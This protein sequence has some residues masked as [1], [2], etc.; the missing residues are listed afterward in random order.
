MKKKPATQPRGFRTLTPSLAVSDVRQAI[1]FYTHAFGAGVQATDNE[2]TPRFATLK[3]GNS[4][5]FVTLGWPELGHVPGM[6]PALAPVSQHM[7]V[8]DADSVFAMALAGGAL[9]VSE[10][11]DV[12]WGERCCVITDP[13]GHHWTIA[14]RIENLTAQEIEERRAAAAGFVPEADMAAEAV[15]A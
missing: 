14:T 2:D 6:L 11:Q 8:E 7:Y 1:D 15:A 13:F 9:A 4:M 12:Y 10:P 3:I 5:V